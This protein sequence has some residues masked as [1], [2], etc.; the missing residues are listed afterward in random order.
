M[1]RVHAKDMTQGNEARLIL[2]FTL[3]LLAGNLLQQLYNIA[4]TAIVGKVLGDDALAAVGATG[5]VTF[6]FSTLCLGLATGAG[7]IISQFFGA[8]FLQRMR[9]AIWNSAAVTLFFGVL[10][11]VLGAVLSEPVQR[12][13]LD[14]PANLLPMSVSYMRIAC[15]GTLAVAAYNWINA[16]M[17]ALGDSKT[18]LLFLGIASVLN[19][20]LDLLFVMVLHTGVAG[21]ALATVLSQLLSAVSCIIYAFV[22]MPELRLSRDDRRIDR[23]MMRLCIRTGLPIAAQSSMISVSMVALQRVTN[24]FGE[25]VMTAYTASMRVEQFIQQPFASLGA[26]LATF[27][28]Q[29]IGAAK[30]ARA[31]QGLRAGLKLSTLLAAGMAVLFWCIGDLVIRCFISGAESV[32]LGYFA[33]RVTS[34]FYIFLG[35]IYVVRGFLN[36]AGD[37][38]Y[39]MM[40][41]IAEV[42]CRVGGALVMTRLLGIGCR[43]IWYTTGLTWLVT[44]IVGLLRYHGG[45]WESK[46]IGAK[47][48]K[49][50]CDSEHPQT[51]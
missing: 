45:A 50:G 34:L 3:P 9:S 36:G 12:L 27:T 14:T 47:T 44:G 6:L 21:A 23:S 18:P 48:Q 28:G 11:S 26:A 49:E 41:G 7:V 42:V 17:R 37:T 32:S 39:A 25:T 5:S 13:L 31:R 15:G 16:V 1:P 40:N 24:G 22:R 33:L 4:D 35:F 46:A 51:A 43:A 2:S 10:I 30:P 8:G 19:V 38:A 20:G 29:N